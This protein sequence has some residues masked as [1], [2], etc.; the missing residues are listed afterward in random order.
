MTQRSLFRH[1]K[2]SPKIIRLAVTTYTRFG[3]S[4]RKLEDLLHERGIDFSHETVR[5]W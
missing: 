3:L 1:F 4:L 5:F 2:S